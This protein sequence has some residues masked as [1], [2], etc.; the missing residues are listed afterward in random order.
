MAFRVAGPVDAAIVLEVGESG[1]P[2]VWVNGRFAAEPEGEAADYSDHI[3]FLI[4]APGGQM[5]AARMEVRIGGLFES[6]VVRL[7]VGGVAVHEDRGFKR[8]ERRRQI[9]RLPLPAAAP[10]TPAD[11]LPLPGR[12]EE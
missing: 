4:P 2:T 3:D 12:L 7:S 10:L 1:D 8:L 6:L 5:L 9:R 11:S